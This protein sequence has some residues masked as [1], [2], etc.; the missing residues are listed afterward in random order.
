[1]PNPVQVADLPARLFR[2]LTPVEETGAAALLDDAWEELIVRVPNL[3]DRMATGEIRTGLVVRVVSAMVN[4]VL[5][6]PDA[7]KQWTVDDASFLRD[8]AITAG[9]LYATEDEVALLAGLPVAESGPIA[10]SAGYSGLHNRP[11]M[12]WGWR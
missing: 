4:R 7:I 6:N 3:E 12:P 11:Q 9:A 1:M 5:R 2:P 8:A 10:F